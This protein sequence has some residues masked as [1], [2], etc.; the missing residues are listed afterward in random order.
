MFVRPSTQFEE[1][2]YDHSKD[3]HKL[4]LMTK[5]DVNPTTSHG[6][7]TNNVPIFQFSTPSRDEVRLAQKKHVQLRFAVQK[8][9]VFE[10]SGPHWNKL[11]SLIGQLISLHMVYFIFE[12]KM[13]ARGD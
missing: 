13:E 8:S 6:I 12:K 1:K 10:N 9:P 7:V 5:F 2:S 3:L 4:K 11:G